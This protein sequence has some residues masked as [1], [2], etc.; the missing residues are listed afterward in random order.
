[1]ASNREITLL[2]AYGIS[3]GARVP[4][5]TV[6]IEPCREYNPEILPQREEEGRLLAEVLADQL[7]IATIEGMVKEFQR[8]LEDPHHPPSAD[9]GR[10]FPLRAI[11]AGQLEIRPTGIVAA[12]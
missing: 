2:G 3:A 6:Y 7:A 11:V 5:V 1:M 8:R 12:K 9:V 10:P 4:I